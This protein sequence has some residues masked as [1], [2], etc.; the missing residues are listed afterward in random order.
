[1]FYYLRPYIHNPF[2]KITRIKKV[3][4][5]NKI[6]CNHY[7]FYDFILKKRELVYVFNMLFIA[8]EEKNVE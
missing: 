5:C 3:D 1:M 2:A 6:I 4:F 7:C 8:I